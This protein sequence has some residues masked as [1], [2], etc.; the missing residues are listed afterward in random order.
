MIMLHV[1]LTA[2][3]RSDVETIRDD[4]TEHARLS[5]AEPG[6][7]RFELLQS[8]E[9]PESFFI[10]EQW[11]SAE[12][13]ETHRGATAFTTIYLPRVVPLVE[14]RAEEV[15]RIESIDAA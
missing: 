6:C 3:N 13:L 11:E 4:L 5:R 2:R 12:A 1:T 9:A 7:Q 15:S 8:R 14:R 10:L